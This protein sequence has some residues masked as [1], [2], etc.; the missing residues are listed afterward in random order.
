MGMYDMF[1]DALSMAQKADNIELV[2]TILDLQQE[3]L[4]LQDKNREMNEENK[5]LQEILNEIKKVEFKGNCYYFDEEGPYCTK[6]YDDEKKKMRMLEEDNNLGVVYYVCP[7]CKTRVF[8]RENKSNMVSTVNAI[9]G[10][11]D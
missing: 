9:E 8:A 10:F 6:C 4:E 5:R 3:M 11:Y 1:K 7:K 2:K